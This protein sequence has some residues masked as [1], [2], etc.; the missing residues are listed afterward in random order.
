LGLR[1]K[2]IITVPKQSMLPEGVTKVQ[3]RVS[4]DLVVTKLPWA[5]F[6]GDFQR[7]GQLSGAAIFVHPR[8][9]DF[10]PTWMA[11]R[12]GLVSV[13]WAGVQPQTFPANEP[14]TCWYRLWIHRGQRTAAEVQQAYDDFAGVLK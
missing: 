2:T 8:H 5:D 13:G 11:R 6:L 12:Y 3:G 7:E 4:G 10:P 9:P 1:T 14:I